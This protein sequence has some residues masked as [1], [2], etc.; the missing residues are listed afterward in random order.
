[1]FV[2]G[3]LV[4]SFT[5]ETENPCLNVAPRNQECDRFI[6][7]T[8]TLPTLGQTLAELNRSCGYC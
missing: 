4:H 7:S 8:L 5:V 2:I 1:M 3:C 6:V